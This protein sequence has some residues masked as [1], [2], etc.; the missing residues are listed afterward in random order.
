E[1]IV[2]IVNEDA[3][4]ASQKLKTFLGGA[5]ANVDIKVDTLAY[6]VSV[7]ALGAFGMSVLVLSNVLVGGLLMVA[8]PV[9]ALV[10]KDRVD[11]EVKKKAIAN[12]PEVVRQVA[13]KI[14]PELAATIDQFGEKLTEWVTNAT[15]D[16]RRSMIEVLNS[17]KVALEDV[18]ADVESPLRE[19]D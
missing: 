15:E 4:D 8:A 14:E 12:A 13:R 1:E 9:L 17:T 18:K 6:D 11:K 16:L 10:F 5:G 7:F 3:R 19:V 2:A